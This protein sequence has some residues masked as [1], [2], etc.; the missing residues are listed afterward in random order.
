MFVFTPIRP[1]GAI[2]Q[3]P[4][5]RT[6]GTRTAAPVV[7]QPSPDYMPTPMRQAAAPSCPTCS[8]R[9]QDCPTC[10]PCVPGMQRA[11]YAPPRWPWILGTVAGGLLA[12]S[13]GVSALQQRKRGR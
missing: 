1:L 10:A 13:L 12:I 9:D 5:T 2:E 3:Q 11:C 6:Y 7:A 4:A 8:C